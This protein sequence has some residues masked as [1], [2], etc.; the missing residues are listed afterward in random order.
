MKS[1]RNKIYIIVVFILLF[2]NFSVWQRVFEL[3]NC[4]KVVFFDVGQGDSIFI[5]TPQGYQILIDGGPSGEKILKKLNKEIPFWDRTI[6]LAVLTHPDTDHLRGLNYV[7]KRYKVKNILWTGIQKNTKTFYYWQKN[8]KKERERDKAKIFIARRGGKIKAGDAEFF[9]LYPFN[10]LNGIFSSK[11][12]NN[13]SIVLMLLFGR[14][15]FLFVGDIDARIESEVLNSGAELKSQVLKIAHHG[16]GHSTSKEFLNAV[17][18]DIAVISVGRNNPY[19][20]PNKETLKKLTEFGI[21][22]LRTDKEGDIKII[23]N[24]WDFLYSQ[25]K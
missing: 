22:V 13:T 20:H 23:S 25:R 8:L 6:D 4:L 11:N 5:E 2:F 7:L 16:S 17:L 12:T 14:N 15:R 10:D 24:G 9:I 19:G 21:K 3:N 1:N 18:P